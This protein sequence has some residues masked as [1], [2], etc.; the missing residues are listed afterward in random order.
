VLF[1]DMLKVWLNKNLTCCKNKMLTEITA[2]FATF[3]D[4]ADAM[5]KSYQAK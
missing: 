3:L 4:I 5:N 1:D 2:A